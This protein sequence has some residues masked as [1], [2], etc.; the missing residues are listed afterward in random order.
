MAHHF[1][2]GSTSINLQDF[3][4]AAV[5]CMVKA[6]PPQ[7]VMAIKLIRNSTVGGIHGLLEAKLVAEFIEA[8]AY[9]N[10][11]SNLI[12]FTNPRPQVTYDGCY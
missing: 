10:T 5:Y 7:K 3:Q 9:T 4:L 6:V 12:A 1:N 2:V 11:D 8:N